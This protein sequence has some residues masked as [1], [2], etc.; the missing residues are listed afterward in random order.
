M[1]VWFFISRK[2]LQNKNWIRRMDYIAMKNIRIKFI[3]NKFSDKQKPCSVFLFYFYTNEKKSHFHYPRWNPIIVN[4]SQL[5]AETKSKTERILMYKTKSLAIL[6][7][8]LLR[9]LCVR[10]CMLTKHIY[11]TSCWLLPML[12]VTEYTPSTHNC[13]MRFFFVCFVC[14][15]S[16]SFSRPA[17]YMLHSIWCSVLDIVHGHTSIV[18]VKQTC[19]FKRFMLLISNRIAS[20]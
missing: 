9:D 11:L 4:V 5:M 12:G 16:D 2:V 19:C 7:K 8:A 17:A 14:F 1:L 3:E 18:C 20:K 13:V 10:L 15:E 6:W